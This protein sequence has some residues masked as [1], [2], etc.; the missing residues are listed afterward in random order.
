MSA[1]PLVIRDLYKAYRVGQPVLDGLSLTVDSG[2]ALALVGINGAGKTTLIKSILDFV[3]IDCGNIE[4]FSESHARH[5]ARARIAFLPERF[6]P[7]YYLTGEGFLRMM[8]RLYRASYSESGIA[9][10]MQALDLPASALSQPVREYS[11][12]MAQKLGLIACLHSQ[13]SL[14]IMDEPMSGLDPKARHAFKQLL[15][16]LPGEG[17][18]L[19][20]STHLLADVEAVCNKMAILHDGRLHFVGSPTECCRQFGTEELENAYM[21]CIGAQV[22]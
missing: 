11:K 5:Q 6:Q 19:F 4:I 3:S 14:L 8:A 10:T 9:A 22:A 13:R 17:R 2:D 16:E 18:T 7:P 15:R 20:F 1:K 12:G 21:Q